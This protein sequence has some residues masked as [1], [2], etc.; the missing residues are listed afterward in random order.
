MTTDL[1]PADRAAAGEDGAATFECPLCRRQL[2]RVRAGPSR[3]FRARPRRPRDGQHPRLAAGPRASAATARP[4]ST[5][6]CSTWAS[7]R[8]WR[9]RGPT[10]LP[11]PVR[12]GALD[13]FRGR[14]VTIAFLDAGFYAHPDLVEP[15][16]R[17]VQYVDITNAR[18]RRD[19]IERPDD[20]SWHGM[21]TSVVACGNGHLSSG[22]YRGVASEA[23]LVLVKVGQMSRIPHENI[24]KGLD[25]VVRN[26]ER[27]GIRIVN[28]SCGGDYAASYLDG[29]AVPGRGSR[30]AERHPGLRRRRQPGPPA[31][32]PRAPAGFGAVG[33]HR[34][35]TGR[36]EPPGL[37]RVRDVPLE[38]RADRRR[39]AEA[40]GHRA[41]HLGGGAHP[42]R[43]PDRGPGAV[44]R[45]TWR[46]R[47]KAS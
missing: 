33:A 27:Y 7:T 23:Q 15:R 45:R 34:G 12:I 21:M 30:H 24:R 9:S 16:D 47:A 17:I 46:A 1:R 43:H 4:A 38:L 42:P 32:P 44:A 37:R 3:L 22:F 11:T 13:E 28:V 14:G 36:P 26:R 20:S 19:D 25:W 18:R 5:P 31:R 6:R 40:G 2:T 29:R 41:R 10:I 35:R 8:R 39:P